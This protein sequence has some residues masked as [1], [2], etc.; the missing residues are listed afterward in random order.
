MRRSRVYVAALALGLL[1]SG[2]ALAVEYEG[3][4]RA[5]RPLNQQAVQAY[6]AENF[7]EAARLFGETYEVYQHPEFLY[8]QAQCYRRANQHRQALEV[9]Q[10][11]LRECREPSA[12]VHLHIGDCHMH[13]SQGDQAIRAYRRYLDNEIVGPGAAHAR[14]ALATAQPCEEHDMQVVEEV[15]QVYAQALRTA[16]NPRRTGEA[17]QSLIQASGRLGI[18]DFLFCA[19]GMYQMDRMWSEAAQAF[20]S[21]L[22]TPHPR[23]EA[24]VD[25]ASCLLMDG[26]AAGA[27]QAA[28]RYLRLEPQGEY[29]EDAQ[30]IVGSR[31]G[32]EGEGGDGGPSAADRARADEIVRDAE[33]L[34]RERQYRQA[35]ARYRAANAIV[36][37]RANL[38]NICMCYTSAEDWPNAALQWEEYLRGGDQGNDAVGHVFAAQAYYNSTSYREAIRHAEAYIALAREHE[39]PA[40][41]PNLRYIEGLMRD[42][43]RELRRGAEE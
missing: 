35:I 31:G 21:Y 11:Y 7:A 18:H 43:A 16:R 32:G 1:W 6:Q 27:R 33:R 38:F 4:P 14:L 10:R 12:N 19:G 2:A 29:A 13:L 3:D 22:A 15:E 39:L 24:W 41:I 30:A 5:A 20:R 37:S 40:E 28:Q 9:Y 36:P 42:T 8:N 34:Y 25:L 26:D 17:A 23:P